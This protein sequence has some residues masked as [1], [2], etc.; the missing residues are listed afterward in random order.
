MGLTDQKCAWVSSVIEPQPHLQSLSLCNNVIG[1]TGLRRLVAALSRSQCSLLVLDL[2]GNM[3]RSQ[4]V[5]VLAEYLAVHGRHLECLDLSS[6]EITLAGAQELARVLR[7]EFGVSLKNL[8]LDMNR[9]EVS[10]CEEL[11]QMLSVN[12]TLETLTL[13]QNNIFNGGCR[14]LFDGLASNS[15]LRVLDI[16]GNFITHVGVRSIRDYLLARDGSQM[17]LRTLNLSTNPLG[18]EGVGV[19]CRGL[20]SD[21]RLANLVIDNV[22]VTDRGARVIRQLLEF[23]SASL[24]T[25]S[26]RHNAQL[27]HIGFAE[28]ALGCKRN[29]NVLRL[30]ADPQFVGWDVVWTKVEMALIR[31]TVYAIDRCTV[32]LLMVARGRILLHSYT[33]GAGTW[34]PVELRRMILNNLDRYQVLTPEQRTQALKIACNPSRSFGTRLEL[35]EAVTGNDYP[36][37]VETMQVINP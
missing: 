4:G 10:G 32:P 26:L 29:R 24:L 34:L 20:Q 16:G 21:C 30:I 35:L 25:I 18:D 2:S 13:S 7:P 1:Y 19:L 27:S 12:K 9:F 31:N 37:I 23:E 8:N 36:S 33:H 17:G 22:D 3:L 15:N 5:Q 6:N 11:G 14:L 28:L